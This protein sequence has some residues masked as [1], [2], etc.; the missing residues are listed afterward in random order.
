LT[1]V[2]IA[3]QLDPERVDCRVRPG[4]DQVNDV[5]VRG[6]NQRWW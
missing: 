5:A 2:S 6:S 3:Q 1:G 4:N